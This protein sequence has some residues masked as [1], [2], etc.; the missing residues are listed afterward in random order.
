MKYVT[1]CRKAALGALL[2]VYGLATNA[3]A[4]DVGV[5]LD[6]S[7]SATPVQEIDTSLDLKS[8]GTTSV[9]GVYGSQEA[10]MQPEATSTNSLWN[11]SLGQS[12]SASAS[13]VVR[14]KEFFMELANLHIDTGTALTGEAT[15]VNLAVKDVTSTDAVIDWSPAVF[16]DVTVYYATTTPVEVRDTTPHVSSWK[17]WKRSQVTLKSLT[18]NTTYFFKAVGKSNLGTTTAESS[19]STT[20]Q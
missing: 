15:F 20:S 5:Y 6:A 10:D 18:P 4:L 11:Y 13:W 14:I 9:E 17:F 12:D 1:T 19:F 16:E 7:A 3:Y 2:L 8:G